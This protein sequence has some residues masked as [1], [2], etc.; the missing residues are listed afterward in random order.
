MVNRR[1][2]I[3]GAAAVLVA[4]AFSRG[5]AA[6]E[7]A[8][9][10]PQLEPLHDRGP[11]NFYFNI[12]K[13]GYEAAYKEPLANVTSYDETMAVLTG[14]AW[15]SYKDAVKQAVSDLMPQL[16]G[17]EATLK[18][19]RNASNFRS[20][21]TDDT[22]RYNEANIQRDFPNNA[23]TNPLFFRIRE[24]AEDGVIT[25]AQGAAIVEAIDGADFYKTE[26]PAFMS[27]QAIATLAA[28]APGQQVP[29]P[30]QF[31]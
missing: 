29:T 11:R 24:L 18:T 4:N 30:S 28:D 3:A 27:E 19:L 26:L 13:Q 6:Q 8:P 1:S 12:A 10:V 23:A 9:V 15:A 21:R 16:A 14:E 20:I 22:R 25:A 17:D 5:V 7:A 31:N 2:F